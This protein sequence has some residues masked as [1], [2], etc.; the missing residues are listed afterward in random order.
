MPKQLPC[1]KIHRTYLFLISILALGV[2]PAHAPLAPSTDAL[3]D[4]PYQIDPSCGNLPLTFEANQ[5]QNDEEVEYL[6]R[7]RGYTLFLTADEAVLALR[8]PEAEQTDSIGIDVVRL[9]LVGAN[10]D[11][12]VS[13]MERQS[14]YSNYFL[15][16][17]PQ[18]WRTHVPHFGKVRYEQV[19]PGIDLVYYGTNQRQLEY[20]FIVSPGA[21][22]DVIRLNFA[23]ADSLYLDEEG[24]LILAN[25]DGELVFRAPVTYQEIS[26]DRQ[27][28]PSRYVLDEF[29]SWGRRLE[30]PTISFDIYSGSSD[31]PLGYAPL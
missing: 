13:S 20:D 24:N 26:G 17:D 3:H 30:T 15:G 10:A 8:R 4:S 25:L 18:T 2:A 12:R 14:G 5:G 28:V 22:P 11:P 31:S 9:Q 21:D 6:S 19:Y 27:Q 23:D 1:R 7:G 16:D 29:D